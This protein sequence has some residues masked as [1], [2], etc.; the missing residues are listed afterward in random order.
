LKIDIKINYGWN[1]KDLLGEG[2]FGKVYKGINTT[3]GQICAVKH[4]DGTSF[5]QEEKDMLEI[6]L[7]VMKKCHDKN[8]IELYWD[9]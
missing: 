9:T 6:E 7:D 1:N 4:M 5:D 3:T 8:L 2:S